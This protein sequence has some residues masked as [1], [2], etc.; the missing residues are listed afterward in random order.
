MTTEQQ[1][2]FWG[3]LIRA[4]ARRPL[5]SDAQ[6]ADL[7]GEIVMLGADGDLKAAADK[8]T[9][10][11]LAVEDVIPHAAKAK[12]VDPEV[13]RQGKAPVPDATREVDTRLA[14]MTV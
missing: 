4:V 8:L 3:R 6:R 5:M 9:A 11:T 13:F 1:S 2:Y 14:A 12:A 10:G 7:A